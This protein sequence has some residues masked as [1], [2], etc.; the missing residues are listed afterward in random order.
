MFEQV[1]SISLIEIKE[2]RFGEG[3]AFILYGVPFF[4]RPRT[5]KQL[6]YITQ[7]PI[8]VRYSCSKGF[9]ADRPRQSETAAEHS[10]SCTS[11]LIL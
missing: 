7:L 11:Y 6:P 3:L 8:D 9:P 4:I 5:L 10:C 2:R 1:S